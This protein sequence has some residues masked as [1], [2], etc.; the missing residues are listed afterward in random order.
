MLS[1]GPTEVLLRHWAIGLVR[2]LISILK[3]PVYRVPC[4]AN[5][6]ADPCCDSN[7][8]YGGNTDCRARSGESDA[9]KPSRSAS[10]AASADRACSGAASSLQLLFSGVVHSRSRW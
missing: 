3:K 4:Q 7:H 9:S 8:S 6:C 1:S 10:R 2:T 5:R